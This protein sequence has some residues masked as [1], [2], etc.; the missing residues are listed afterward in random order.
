MK[1]ATNEKG[2]TLVEVLAALVILGIMFVGIMTI[3][4]QMTLFNA[5]TETKL[6]TMNLARLEMAKITTADK[7]EKILV[8]SPTD[9]TSLEPQFLSKQKIE[10]EL[11]SI[12]Y[13]KNVAGSIEASPYS[14]TS[15]VRYQKEDAAKGLRYEADIYLKCEPFLLKVSSSQGPNAKV[16][17]AMDDRIKLYKVHLKVFSKKNSR[18]GTYQM[19]SET[20]SFIRYTAKKPLATTTPGGG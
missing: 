9:P 10:T 4:P 7:W 15:F 18:N 11:S 8:T 17:C 16:E 6:D 19:S 14:S 12:Q 5:R 3:F 2:L 1:P 13:G 20:Y